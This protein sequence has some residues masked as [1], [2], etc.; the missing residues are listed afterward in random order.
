MKALKEKNG[1]PMHLGRDNLGTH[2]GRRSPAFPKH[3]REVQVTKAQTWNHPPPLPPTLPGARQECPKE[4]DVN[5][6][7]T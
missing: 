5:K 1:N 2:H 6:N 4:H 7:K 3:V